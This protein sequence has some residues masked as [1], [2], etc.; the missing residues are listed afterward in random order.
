M[1]DLNKLSNTA[2]VE[3]QHGATLELAPR[4]IELT[5]GYVQSRNTVAK[6]QKEEEEL[7]QV[8]VQLA[9]EKVREINTLKAA[10]DELQCKATEEIT[11]LKKAQ[12]YLIIEKAQLCASVGKVE[13]AV[14][15]AC[16]HIFENTTELTAF[17]KAKRLGEVISQ[18][19]DTN[20]L[21]NALVHLETPPE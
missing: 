15:E 2:L 11:E 12:D 13:Q 6:L 3:L 20:L 4:K 18:L 5:K 16:Q 19:Q 9:K 10:R 7:H 8:K 1:L 21:L 17:A 14:D